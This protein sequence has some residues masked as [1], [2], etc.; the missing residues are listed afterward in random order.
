MAET[1]RLLKAISSFYYVYVGSDCSLSGNLTA[2]GLPCRARG[3]LRLNGVEPTPGDY[4]CWQPDPNHSDSGVLTGIQPRKNFFIRPNIA[5]V[6]QLV[7]VASAARP[8]TD[9]W[10][11]DRL[12]V[13]AIHAGCEFVVCLNKTD[14]NP[15]DELFRVYRNAGF[16]VY[17]TSA[18][19]GR[20]IAEFS[21]C[22]KGKLSVL[23]G[24][25]GV[26]KTSLLNRLVPG[27]M[28]KTDE[29]SQKHGRGKHTTRHTELFP[30]EQNGWI[31]DT[32][33][34]A[35]LDLQLL[36]ALSEEDLPLCFPEFPRDRCRFPDCRHSAEP[37]CAVRRAVEEGHV[38][39]SRYRSYLRILKE[40]HNTERSN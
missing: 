19:D 30:L 17:R 25:S 28:Q 37:S 1:G 20:G 7:F 13:S 14:L 40:V 27:V 4:V 38:E 21:A 31:A 5:N 36:S 35:A 10:L 23:T 22:L 29:I 6:D 24:N 12:S 11:I 26:G 33:G 34:F 2:F 16:P 32:P 18:A 8:E 39:K 15:A 9:P 3:R